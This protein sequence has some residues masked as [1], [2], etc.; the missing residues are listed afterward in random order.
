MPDERIAAVHREV[1]ARLSLGMFP[2]ASLCL[3]R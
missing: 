2:A 3:T 1:A